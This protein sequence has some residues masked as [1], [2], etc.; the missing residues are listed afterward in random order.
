[1]DD[2]EMQQYLF[3]LQGYLVVEEVLSRRQVEVLN[4]LLDQQELPGPSEGPRFGAAAGG[5]PEGPGFLA[6]G[7]PFCDLLDHPRIMPLLRLRLG[8]CFRLDRLYGMCMSAG[9]PMGGLH[10]DFGASG[11]RARSTPGQYYHPPENE[12][13]NSFVV[14]GWNLSATGPDYGGFCCIPG[15]H[16]SHFRLPQKIKEAPAQAPQVV[17][18]AAAAGSAIL[19]TESL[20]HGTAAWT[21]A[22]QRRTLLYKYCVAHTAWSSRRVRPPANVELS[23]RQQLLFA[24]PA[25]PHRFFPSLFAANGDS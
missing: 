20:T 22:H 13:L 12:L 1:M 7:Q 3:D 6:W 25:D 5:A 10:A 15:S 2:L 8:D 17:I 19:F 24:E 23:V 16:K 21:G 18:P 11:H 4:Q 14:V 9:M